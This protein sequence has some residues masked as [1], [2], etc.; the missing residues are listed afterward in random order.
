MTLIDFV[1]WKLQTS[2]SESDKSLKSHVS[3]EASTSNM[4]DVPKQATA[5]S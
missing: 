2:K 3:E 4:V 5:I 1:F